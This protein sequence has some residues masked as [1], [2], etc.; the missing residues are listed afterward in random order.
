MLHK[1]FTSKMNIECKKHLTS[2]V[3][4]PKHHFSPLNQYSSVVLAILSCFVTITLAAV[5]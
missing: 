1:N 3:K 5:E 4:S 2:F